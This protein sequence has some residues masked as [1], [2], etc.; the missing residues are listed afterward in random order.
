MIIRGQLHDNS[1]KIN[2]LKHREHKELRGFF[3]L[4]GCSFAQRCILKKQSRTFLTDQRKVNRTKNKKK[5][6]FFDFI[7]FLPCFF[8]WPH[9]GKKQHTVS[10]VQVCFFRKNQKKYRLL[11]CILLFLLIFVQ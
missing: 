10:T 4:Y 3:E 5:H 8:N 1:C 7:W 6:V 9:C 11:V 2:G